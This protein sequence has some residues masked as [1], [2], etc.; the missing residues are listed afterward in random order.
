MRRR[1]EIRHEFVEFVPAE[2]AEG[3]L[4][5]SLEYGTA[6]HLCCCGCGN[7]AVTPL[8]PTDWRLIFDG[9]TVSLDPSI[10]NW[11]FDCH[12]HYWIVRGKIRWTTKWSRERIEE[13]RNWDSASKEAFFKAKQEGEDYDP[14]GRRE[15]LWKR[16]LDWWD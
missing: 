6:S 16:L 12:S 1:R 3:V 9:E 13:G 15:S 8:S 10:G 5:V 7:K 14:P 2:L 11:S 4:Y